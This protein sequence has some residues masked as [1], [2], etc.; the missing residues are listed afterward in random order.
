MISIPLVFYFRPRAGLGSDSFCFV[1]NKIGFL[2]DLS[3][4]KFACRTGFLDFT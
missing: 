2:I 4:C 3:F 1:W